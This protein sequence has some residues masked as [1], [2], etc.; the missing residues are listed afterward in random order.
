MVPVTA[1]MWGG[2]MV[3]WGGV[4]GWGFLYMGGLGVFLLSSSLR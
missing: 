4:F 3:V 1:S 2:G